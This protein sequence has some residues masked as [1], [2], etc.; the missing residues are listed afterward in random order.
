MRVNSISTNYSNTYNK[1][2][3]NNS[4]PIKPQ[5]QQVTFT[6]NWAEGLSIMNKARIAKKDANYYQKEA[7]KLQNEAVNLY[8]QGINYALNGISN[9]FRPIFDKDR[10]PTVIFQ[11]ATGE[12]GS[13]Y[14][15]KITIFKNEGKKQKVDQYELTPDG[16]ITS[17]IVGGEVN[18]DQTHCNIDKIFIFENENLPLP[19]VYSLAEVKLDHYQSKGSYSRT[20]TTFFFDNAEL[21]LLEKNS[22]EDVKNNVKKSDK[23]WEFDENGLYSYSINDEDNTKG[24]KCGEF[25]GFDEKGKLK[26]DAVGLK[27]SED[28][29]STTDI[30]YVFNG[31]KLVN[32][33]NDYKKDIPIE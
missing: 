8:N 28:G 29:S 18:D 11:P 15:Q 5:A 9:E 3:F 26:Y 14:L 30:M 31:R 7:V 22:L 19:T 33:I 24:L 2:N 23:C 25:I 6:G 10:K 1:I 13:Q 20:G 32:K 12:D 27:V 21:I 4:Q 16:L 17:I